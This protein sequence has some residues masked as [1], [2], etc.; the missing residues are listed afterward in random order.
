MNFGTLFQEIF[1]AP[2]PRYALAEDG[3]KYVTKGW[4]INREIKAI[5]HQLK[6]A[7]SQTTESNITP[8]AFILS[9][10]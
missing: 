8:E 6:C 5:M 2:K 4:A 9:L 10:S 7:S 3:E 1:M